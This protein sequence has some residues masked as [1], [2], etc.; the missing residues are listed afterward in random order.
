MDWINN[1]LFNNDSIAHIVLLYSFVIVIGVLL[2]RIKIFGVSLGVSFVLFAG[3]FVGHFGFTANPQILNFIQ[4]FGLILFVY[5]IGL[6]VGPSF[7]SS[8]M[9]GGLKM[10]LLAVI[11]ILLSVVIML[12]LWLCLFEKEDLPMLVGVM[13]GAV[14]NTPSLGAASEALA[15]SGYAGGNIANAYA[16]AYPLGVVGIIL[17]TILLRH[18]CRIQIN[19]ESEELKRSSSADNDAEA[20]RLFVEVKNEAMV[21]KT[22]S[23][24][25]ELTNRNFVCSRILHEGKVCLPSKDSVLQLSDKAVI[26]CAKADATAIATLIG[27]QLDSADEI[28]QMK[29]TLIARKII[30]TNSKI[31]GKSLKDLHLNGSYDVNVTRVIRS[32]IE[33]FA[34]PELNL[35]VGD[36]LIVVGS[37][38]A[39]QAVSEYLGNSL[40]NL[41]TPNILTIFFGILLGIIVGSIPIAFPGMPTPVKLGLAGG[42]LVIAILIS[43]FGY[44]MK[45]VT[46]T[47][48]SANLM[49]REIGL[50]LF[51]ASVGIK[52]GGNFINTVTEGDGLLYVLCGFIITLVPLIIIG[53]IARLKYKMNYFSMMG[54]IAGVT[55]DPP[56]LAYSNQ[57]AGNDAPAIAY[58]TV[59]PLSMFLR[60]LVAQLVIMLFMH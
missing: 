17:S 47:T 27:R 19:K 22:L 9:K 46:Y 26:I 32:D 30:V 57:T 40:K 24:I 12:L 51:L 43:R 54:L 50:S 15:Q 20:Y 21:G 36:R 6:Q 29:T 10:N 53:L 56:A 41:N 14:T 39:I 59:Y 58:T 16:C 23:Q 52:A 42:P 33:L 25:R 49:L 35:Y 4:D 34:N 60:I 7:F 1:L 48:L 11:G 18:I 2:G 38:E 28:L 5:C 3:I 37:E 8:L 13:C 55:T 45:M 31:N 44:K